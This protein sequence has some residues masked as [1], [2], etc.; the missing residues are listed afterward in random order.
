LLN[1]VLGGASCSQAQFTQEDLHFLG[2]RA[3]R[4]IRQL[5]TAGAWIS[6]TSFSPLRPC[7][8]LSSLRMYNARAPDLTPVGS[9]TRLLELDLTG[10]TAVTS[11][12][13]LGSLFQLQSLCLWA[14]ASLSSL[15][16]ID[17]C[18]ALKTLNLRNCSRISNLEQL[19]SLT[20]L[21]DLDLSYCVSLPPPAF[22]PLAL[23]TGLKV[24]D[25]RECR[26][27]FDLAPL[28]PCLDLRRLYISTSTFH[29][30]I[31]LNLEPLFWLHHLQ[32]KDSSQRE[33]RVDAELL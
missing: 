1:R 5:V 16:G 32:V 29:G 24:L 19:S 14:C 30:R 25:I 13:P 2:T 21:L 7:T 3:G 4:L 26:A 33:E 12:R 10:C 27:V 31:S 18:T 20:N 8:Q 22:S 23:C 15:D 6:I 17:S 28:A 11:L 9:L